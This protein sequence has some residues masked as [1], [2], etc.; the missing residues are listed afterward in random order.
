MTDRYARIE[1]PEEL[2]KSWQEIADILA[3]L[4]GVPA[5]LIMRYAA[6]DIEVF[7][8]SSSQGNPYNPGDKEE[9]LGSGLYCEEV[10]S[11]GNFLL[12]PDARQDKKWMNNPDIKLNMISYLGFPIN[13][14]QGEPFGTIC[15]LDNRANGYS[16]TVRNLMGKFR[17]LI[18]NN[19]GTVYLNHFLG[20]KN[21]RLA[22]YLFELQA[23]RGFV[24]M[25][26]GCK[27]IQDEQGAWR[28]VEYYL[29]K[30]PESEI[31]H[32]LCP[33]CVERLYP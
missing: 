21:R 8:S 5:A 25:C 26:A 3:Q 13:Y 14:P 12:V 24:R 23:L 27:R 1:F 22:D 4:A 30:N 28:P 6:P 2:R 33:E 11:S 31:T 15:V 16:E 32:G 7:V 29:G 17:D 10:I 18:E 20:E 9:L 19:L